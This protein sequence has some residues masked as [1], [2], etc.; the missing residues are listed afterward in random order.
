MTKNEAEL[1][2]YMKKAGDVYHL[3]KSFADMFYI[4]LGR[5]VSIFG[6]K[7]YKDSVMKSIAISLESEH[8]AGFNEGTIEAMKK[9]AD[10]SDK[11]MK[12]L[13]VFC[14]GV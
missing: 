8:L 4:P 3:M 9:E 5:D 12:S 10:K 1:T 14:A 11:L 13:S 2:P 7:T 6:D